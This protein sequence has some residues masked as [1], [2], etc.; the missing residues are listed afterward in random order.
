[1]AVFIKPNAIHF[2]E[3]ENQPAAAAQQPASGS[4]RVA[5]PTDPSS[6]G[7]GWWPTIGHPFEFVISS[8]V[9]DCIPRVCAVDHW[10]HSINGARPFNAFA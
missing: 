6:A 3:E 8:L 1:M 10:M 7:T 5:D 2:S 4:R 9:S